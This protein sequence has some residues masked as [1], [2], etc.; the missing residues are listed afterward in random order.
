MYDDDKHLFANEAKATLY[1]TSNHITGLG[2]DDVTK[3][4]HVGTLSGRSDFDSLSRINSTTSGITSRISA[5]HGVIAE[6]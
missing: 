6:E 5:S 4:L 3:V 1:G 2:Y